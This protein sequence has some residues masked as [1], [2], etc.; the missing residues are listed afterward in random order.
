MQEEQVQAHDDIDALVWN[1]PH[2][3]LAGKPFI[4]VVF[5][6]TMEPSL[7]TPF[8]TVTIYL[9]G[10]LQAD[11]TWKKAKEEAQK[12]VEC[13]YGIFWDID[14]GL[15]EQLPF[16]LTNQTQY[17]SLALSLEHF[18]DSLWKEFKSKTI[19]VSIYRG[20]ADFSLGFRWDESQVANLRQWLSHVFVDE[21]QFA[22]EISVKHSS[23]AQLEVTDLLQSEAGTQLVR[24]FCRDVSLEYL[25][26]L[27]SRLPDTLPVYL[28]L[29]VSVFISN[30]LWQAQL[31]HA[32]R[33]EHLNLALNGA[34]LPIQ[35]WGWQSHMSPLGY[36]G[37]EVPSNQAVQQEIKVGVCLP[38][39][40]MCRPGQFEGLEEALV[41][42]LQAGIPF[43][44]I[45]ENH[46]ITEWDGLD[47]LVYT[48]T[49]L[50][51]QG[52]RK[53][54]GFCAAGG[55]VL[56]VGHLLGLAYEESFAEFMQSNA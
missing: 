39:M 42:L 49:G 2:Y 7:H 16:A 52:K 29:N 1:S 25:S 43:R 35:A 34:T 47:Y 3:T 41:Q 20:S 37:Q 27:A 4:P 53:L 15:F 18:R 31:L 9:D 10:R 33:F 19:G 24:L 23:F 26:L 44:I 13:G 30:P 32:E 40:T 45:A 50:S 36:S 55:T 22:S 51:V 46:L 38:S 17:L 48:P 8:N 21:A 11:L 14:I 5:E 54:Q 12:A 28:F 6:G 56:S